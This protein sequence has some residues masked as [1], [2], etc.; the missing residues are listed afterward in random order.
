MNTLDEK[1]WGRKTRMRALDLAHSSLRPTQRCLSGVSG[2]EDGGDKRGEWQHGQTACLIS[3][4][5]NC[6]RETR[7]GHWVEGQ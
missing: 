3:R 1:V 2:M 5:R 6:V 7:P 4:G